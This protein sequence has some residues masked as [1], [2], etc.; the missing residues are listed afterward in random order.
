MR[1]GR[2]RAGLLLATSAVALA[3]AAEGGETITYRYDALG[4][5]TAT[6]TSGTVNN[7]VSTAVGYDPAGNRSSYAVA[8][9]SGP[10]PPAPPPPAPPS[11]PPSPPPAPPPPANIPPTA[12]NNGGSQP[13]C[14]TGLY[15]VVSDD[16]DADGDTPL[17]L[18]SVS[19][20]GFFVVSATEIQFNST[21][22]TGHKI[23]TYVV[24]D[25]RGATASATLDVNVAGGVCGP[26]SAQLPPPPGK[27]GS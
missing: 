9:G 21:S 13:K 3:S 24:R 12:T 14:S 6:S 20:S 4:R 18:V 2:G 27:I 26:Q 23:G 8:G 5:L 1:K 22:S 25:A 15:D 11:P 16:S 7:G 10:P 17:A 19:G